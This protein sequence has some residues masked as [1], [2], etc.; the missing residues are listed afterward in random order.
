MVVGL[1]FMIDYMTASQFEQFYARQHSATALWLTAQE[2]NS[3]TVKQSNSP[4]TQLRM[5]AEL[6]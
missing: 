5:F 6:G 1:Q 2:P 4:R 3:L